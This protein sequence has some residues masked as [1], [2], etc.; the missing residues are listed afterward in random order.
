[1]LD[2]YPRS[3]RQKM[4]KSTKEHRQIRGKGYLAA[5]SVLLTAILLSGCSSVPSYVNPVHWY[6]SVSDWVSGPS[7]SE[8]SAANAP[9]AEDFSK[10]PSD[11]RPETTSSENRTKIIQG[12]AADRA[13]AK[14]TEQQINRDGSATRPLN[15][16]VAS[17]KPVRVI[18]QS[19]TGGAA[20]Q[21]DAVQQQVATASS[22]APAAGQSAQVSEPVP[23]KPVVSAEDAPP[24]PPPSMAS[25]QA[26]PSTPTSVQSS[27][28]PSRMVAAVP[29]PAPARPET[30]EEAYRRR[31]AEFDSAPRLSSAPLTP[32]PPA[33]AASALRPTNSAATTVALTSERPVT[34][35]PPSQ[36]RKAKYST[37]DGVQPLGKFGGEGSAASFEVASVAFG[38]GTSELS[39]TEKAQ[40]QQV[41]ALYRQSGG[42]VRVFGRSDSPRLDVDPAANREAN[43]QLATQRADAVAHAL[44]RLGIPASKIY[45][46]RSPDSQDSLALASSSGDAAT[47]IYIDY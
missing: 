27:A 26:S 10:L 37:R 3:I 5:G 22:V 4:Y 18:A 31:L 35:I 43:R 1:M 2:R 44:I 47:E 36:L 38:E 25:V 8:A 28:A 9:A 12:L 45:A 6:R 29:T 14:Y 46:G 13:N 30:V 24:P 23:A 15:P 39:S 33:F 41:A 20:Q 42:S 11:K 16:D 7:E 40:L 19:E 34:L 17:S 21:G 32:T